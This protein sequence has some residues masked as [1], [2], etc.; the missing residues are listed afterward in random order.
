MLLPDLVLP[1]RVLQHWHY[2]GLDHPERCYN[3]EYFDSFPY[4]VEYHYNSRGFRDTEWPNEFDDVIWCL[5]DSFTV[6]LGSPRAHTWPWLLQRITGKR[7]VNVSMDG[8]SNEWISR[9]ACDILRAGI[10]QR[11]VIHWSYTHRRENWDMTEL[12]NQRWQTLYN[13]VKDPTWP[14]C[15]PWSKRYLLPPQI[16]AEIEN[17]PH[18]PQ[19]HVITDEHRR[20]D[21]P[22][23]AAVLD[24]SI[25]TE[26]FRNC[27][28]C[29]EHTRGTAVVVHSFIPEFSDDPTLQGDIAEVLDCPD[30][31]WIPEVTRLD[32]ARDYHHYDLVTAH[33]L[34]INIVDLLPP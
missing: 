28:R 2:T 34:A 30:L 13:D 25:N 18:W 31:R 32:Y 5:G 12:L 6:G 24:P 33:Q 22:E 26:N 27:L 3:P 10:A 8:A 29:V 14:A 4:L 21:I 11:M 16:R 15:P 7:T 17:N 19:L 20:V 23:R 9:R 1:S